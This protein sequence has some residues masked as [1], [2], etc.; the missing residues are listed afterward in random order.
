MPCSGHNHH[1]F[2]DGS[3]APHVSVVKLYT[4]MCDRALSLGTRLWLP[5]THMASSS[6]AQPP[7][8]VRLGAAGPSCNAVPWTPPAQ[9]ARGL[10]PGNSKPLGLADK[11]LKS[12]GGTWRPHRGPPENLFWAYQPEK[13]RLVYTETSGEQ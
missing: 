9:H 11:S 5:S 12:P 10:G 1:T 13:R 2:P 4:M 6:T 7:Y 8:T 3:S